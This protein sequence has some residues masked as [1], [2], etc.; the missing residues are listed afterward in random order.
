M[1]RSMLSLDPSARLSFADYLT[2]NR[3]NAFP[4]IFY[5][6]LHPFIS[7]LDRV[8]PASVSSPTAAPATTAIRNGAAVAASVDVGAGGQQQQQAQQPQGPILLRTDADEKIERIWTE[9]EMVTRYLDESS[10]S[11]LSSTVTATAAAPPRARP[12]AETEQSE[13]RSS[14]VSLSSGI[15]I[16]VCSSADV[17]SEQLFFPICLNLPGQEGVEMRARNVTEGDF[18]SSPFPQSQLQTRN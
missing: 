13:S 5:T 7:S 10:S 17:H 18:L 14:G 8:V 9:W 11:S 6:F 16:L 4:E 1:I 15:D 12:D 3:G 2:Q